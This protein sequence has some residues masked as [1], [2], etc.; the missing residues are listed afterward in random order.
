MKILTIRTGDRVGVG[1][2]ISDNHSYQREEC[3][4]IF[5][6]IDDETVRV[7]K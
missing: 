7:E 5:H 6:Q 4:V 1:Y 2:R 3:N